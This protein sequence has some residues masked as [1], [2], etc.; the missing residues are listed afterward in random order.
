MNIVFLKE[1][2]EECSTKI[3][4]ATTR[5]YLQ[6]FLNIYQD[7]KKSNRKPRELLREFQS[8]VR[9]ISAWNV[10]MIREEYQKFRSACEPFDGIVRSI[11]KLH[12]SIYNTTHESEFETNIPNPGQYIHETYLNIARRLWK[13]PNLVYD[14]K[15]DKLIYQKNI[16]RL[17]KII[18]KCLHDTFVLMLP[19]KEF[20]EELAQQE[21]ESE[22]DYEDDDE[23]D[24]EDEAQEEE[25]EIKL[26]RNEEQADQTEQ[27]A[28]A[29]GKDEEEDELDVIDEEDGMVE[30]CNIVEHNDEI[31][32]A[33]YIDN[34]L[35]DGIKFDE[36]EE[37]AVEAEE[38]IE[39]VEEIEADKKQ[40]ELPETIKEV[41]RQSHEHE[42][43]M[44]YT[45]YSEDIQKQPRIDNNVKIILI[46]EDEKEK[47]KERLALAAEVVV[48]ELKAAEELAELKAEAA[49][50]NVA[51]VESKKEAVLEI[52]DIK[53]IDFS[54]QQL[55]EDKVSLL[56]PRKTLSERKKLVKTMIKQK[57]FPDFTH[58][59]DS[60]F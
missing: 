36:E 24:D 56:A 22:D 44:K 43:G 8:A 13:E 50:K 57:G 39:E 27:A 9:E 1:K 7:V 60:F 46:G 28:F 29:E 16:I 45:L 37:N 23:D 20:D 34:T 19:F 12:L 59:K 10:D 15:V 25:V 40:I 18:R 5:L 17:E 14:V 54:S 3:E 58:V 55:K 41:H 6:T 31:H 52:S 48:E 51:D 2:R 30:E 32:Q 21:I 11:F 4:R 38:E 35:Y 26:L 33:E 47:E 53:V 49:A 42:H